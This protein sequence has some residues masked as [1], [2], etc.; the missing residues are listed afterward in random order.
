M[1]K[2]EFEALPKVRVF[3]PVGPCLN[4]FRFVK[5][6]TKTGTVVFWNG[7][8]PSYRRF[9]KCW[10]HFEPCSSCVD[11]PHTQYPYGYMD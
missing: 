9:V 7:N 4:Y 1:T 10:I 6:N 5:W 2:E 11:H 8:E 3:S